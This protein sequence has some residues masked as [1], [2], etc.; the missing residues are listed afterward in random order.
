MIYTH[1]DYNIRKKGKQHIYLT[2]SKLSNGKLETKLSP[3]SYDESWV[4]ANNIPDLIIDP[5]TG[6]IVLIYISNNIGY[7]SPYYEVD[8]KTQTTKTYEP[9]YIHEKEL[10]I[11]SRLYK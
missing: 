5:S 7:V 6:E 9:I 2:L 11:E 3:S 10:Y 8:T 1:T 4:Q